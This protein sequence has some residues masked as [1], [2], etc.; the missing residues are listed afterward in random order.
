ML[1][2]IQSEAITE[3]LEI[4]KQMEKDKVNKIPRKFL[5][6]LKNNSS[7]TYNFKTDKK[8][9]LKNQKLKPETKALLALIY[10]SY[11]CESEDEKNTYIELLNRNELEY[12]RELSEK[13]SVAN[14]FNKKEDINKPATEIHRNT[15]LVVKKENIFFKIINNIRKTFFRSKN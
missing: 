1:N 4:L 3:V 10:L 2:T 7:S 5:D 15:Q 14:L 9:Q 11:W 12:Q 13:Y 6:F 8:V